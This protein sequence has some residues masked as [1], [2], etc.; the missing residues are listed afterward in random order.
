[1]TKQYLWLVIDH[2]PDKDI[3]RG[4]ELVVCTALI[5]PNDI[6]NVPD[7]Y[8]ENIYIDEAD[9]SAIYPWTMTDR[10]IHD[11]FEMPT[12]EQ[13]EIDKADAEYEYNRRHGEVPDHEAD[14]INNAIFGEQEREQRGK[15][16][17]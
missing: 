6:V 15:R 17:E 3:R 14:A 5:R 1:M 10:N 13:D 11:A 2:T 8:A 16:G 9:G 7:A 4:P 12:P